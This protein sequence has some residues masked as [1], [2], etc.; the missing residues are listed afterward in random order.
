MLDIVSVIFVNINDDDLLGFVLRNLTNKFT[1]DT[2]TTAS[3]HTNFIFDIGTDILVIKRDRV[4]TE[5][6][7]DLDITN[8]SCKVCRTVSDRRTVQKGS[9]KRK[10]LHGE[11]G[12]ATEIENCLAVL[13]RATGNGKK[14]LFDVFQLCD[15]GNIA[16]TAR[17]KHVF[18]RLA[19]FIAI[20]VDKADRINLCGGRRC[21]TVFGILRTELDFVQQKLGRVPGTDNHGTFFAA[22]DTSRIHK[23]NERVSEHEAEKA[24]AN[25]CENRL[26]QGELPMQV[27]ANNVKENLCRKNTASNALDA[28]EVI[29]TIEITP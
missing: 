27:V 14:N 20:I 10:H 4:T 7:F 9:D 2:T 24:Y 1:T 3:H 16:C 23:R 8:L 29:A 17:D 5:Q 25:A 21:N 18:K 28:T 13:G 19:Y 26:H 6:V 15:F 11:S 22:F 12:F